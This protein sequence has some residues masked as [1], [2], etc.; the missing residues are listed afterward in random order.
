MDGSVSH[1]CTQDINQQG[2]EA[3]DVLHASVFGKEIDALTQQMLPE[4]LPDAELTNEYTSV[5]F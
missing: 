2:L 3:G 5:H 4:R 1:Q